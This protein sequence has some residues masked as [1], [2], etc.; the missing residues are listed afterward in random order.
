VGR[1][2][3]IFSHPELVIC[4]AYEARLAGRLELS[5]EDDIARV[6]SNDVWDQSRVP[7]APQQRDHEGPDHRSR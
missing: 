7:I 5:E 4:G 6:S 3:T 2:V 1:E